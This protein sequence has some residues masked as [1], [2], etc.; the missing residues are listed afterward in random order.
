[1]RF[2][3]LLLLTLLTACAPFSVNNESL[4][5]LDR[6]THTANTL[7]IS[8]LY[9][10]AQ[11]KQRV[12]YIHGTPGD[13]AN[14]TRYLA[15]PVEGTSSISIDRPGFGQ[16]EPRGAVTSLAEQAAAIEPLLIEQGGA[17]PILVGHS[18]GAPVAAWLAAEHPGRVAG[19][20][21]LAGALDPGL[22]RVQLIQRVGDFA[23]MPWFLPRWA[24][25]ANREL[26]ALEG[27][28]RLLE[29][30][31]KDVRCPVVIVHGTRD[32][33]VPYANVA[34]MQDTL[35]HAIKSSITLEGAGH[36]LPWKNEH[37]LRRAIKSL[38]DATPAADSGIMK[39]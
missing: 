5:M 16:S 13:A 20:V 14:F 23:F 19:I 22:E 1:M 26:I 2:L 21:L 10:K 8:A 25:N 36:F 28:L 31:L 34:Y 4:T 33:L 37:D 6:R 38:Q 30:K 24:R 35:G 27:E 18:L 32:K 29:T 15:T 17:M 7:N 12:I 9:S 3:T 11:T 39:Q